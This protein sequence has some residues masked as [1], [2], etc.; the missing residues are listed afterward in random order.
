[1]SVF[2]RLILYKTEKS[3]KFDESDNLN[4]YVT[5][6]NSDESDNSKT[7]HALKVYNYYLE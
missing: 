2:I 6:N 3:N 1:M 5:L 4:P 7:N